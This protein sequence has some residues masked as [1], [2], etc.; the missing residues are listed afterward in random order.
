MSLVSSYYFYYYSAAKAASFG[1]LGSSSP[2]MTTLPQA[3]L[4][5]LIYSDS[6][7]VSEAYK[8]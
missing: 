7:S 3:Y 1:N 5:S 4:S 8:R 6:D 2:L